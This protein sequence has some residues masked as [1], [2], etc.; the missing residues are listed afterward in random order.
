MIAIVE[1]DAEYGFSHFEEVSLGPHAAVVDAAE[2]LDV[3]LSPDEEVSDEVVSPGGERGTRR[4]GVGWAYDLIRV[5]APPIVRGQW[6]SLRG[7]SSAAFFSRGK[8]WTSSA[9]RRV[10]MVD[11]CCRSCREASRVSEGFRK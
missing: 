1:D 10:S 7:A 2:A 9:A 4:E 3:V 8:A 6:M 5:G 11:L